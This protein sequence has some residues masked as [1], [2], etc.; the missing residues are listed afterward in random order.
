ML[1]FLFEGMDGM[2]SVTRASRGSLSDTGGE[3]SA[4]TPTA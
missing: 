3:L 1:L 4:H 2:I